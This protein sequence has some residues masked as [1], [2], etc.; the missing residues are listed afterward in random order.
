MILV[1]Q[2]EIEKVALPSLHLQ[3]SVQVLAQVLTKKYSVSE[4]SPVL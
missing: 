4:Y 1:S 3:N 2:M